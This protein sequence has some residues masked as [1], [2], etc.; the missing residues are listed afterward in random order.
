MTATS[1]EMNS[2]QE[3]SPVAELYTGKGYVHPT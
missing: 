2:A 1:L 3:S